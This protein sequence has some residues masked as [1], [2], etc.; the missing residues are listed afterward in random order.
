MTSRRF[1]SRQSSRALDTRLLHSP[2]CTNSMRH[3]RIN[4]CVNLRK[5]DNCN[6]QRVTVNLSTNHVLF[7]R[8]SSNADRRFGLGETTACCQTG[9][10]LTTY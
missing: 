1:T 5:I 7:T 2:I 6:C 4:R 3:D 9:R 8:S 10:T